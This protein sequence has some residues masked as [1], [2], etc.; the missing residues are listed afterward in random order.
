MIMTASKTDYRN[1]F[2]PPGG[3][4]IWIIIFLELIT[5]S[6]GLHAM[7]YYGKAESSLFHACSLTVNLNIAIVNTVIVV[8][9]SYFM[10]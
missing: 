9:S 6:L 3:I 8:R 4:L 5:F 1:I 7:V 2:Y 10:A